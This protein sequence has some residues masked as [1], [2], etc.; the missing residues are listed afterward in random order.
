MPS[1]F[2]WPS[3]LAARAYDVGSPVGGGGGAIRH[4]SELVTGHGSAWL[5]ESTGRD[6]YGDGDGYGPHR[7][8]HDCPS[9]LIYE[10]Y[11]S[12]KWENGRLYRPN[13]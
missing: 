2:P 6:D 4:P 1:G 3:V 7:G 13:E 11:I 8:G 12:V 9:H 5:A 10:T